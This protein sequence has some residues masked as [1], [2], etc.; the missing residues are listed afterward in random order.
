MDHQQRSCFA[1]THS[2]DRVKTDD[3]TGRFRSPEFRLQALA[4]VAL[5]LVA[6]CGLA[7]C[8][9]GAAKIQSPPSQTPLISIALA[10]LPPAVLPVSTSAQVSATV[11]NDPANA[12]VDWVA[13]C[14][15]AGADCGHFAPAHTDSG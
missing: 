13:T 7:G 8:T 3:Q 2:P 5:T 14:G 10:Q 12:G 4:S 11:S 15:K 6:F 9:T 1:Q